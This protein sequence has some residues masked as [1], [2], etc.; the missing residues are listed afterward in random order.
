MTTNC[1][2]GRV[3][4]DREC[5]QVRVDLGG[6]PI[7]AQTLENLGEDHANCPLPTLR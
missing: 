3:A 6:F 5:E 1:N 2:S 7:V 4:K